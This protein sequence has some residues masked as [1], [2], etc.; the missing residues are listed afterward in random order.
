MKEMLK[1]KL[2]ENLRYRIPAILLCITLA[3]GLFVT[4]DYSISNYLRLATGNIFN[5]FDYLS[6]VGINIFFMFLFRFLTFAMILQFLF[7]KFLGGVENSSRLCCF[8]LLHTLIAMFC[9]ILIF[10][11]IFAFCGRSIEHILKRFYINNIPRYVVVDTL[12]LFGTNW[13]LY[14][15]FYSIVFAVPATAVATPLLYFSLCNDTKSKKLLFISVLFSCA[16]CYAQIGMFF[17]I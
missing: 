10:V 9:A 4:R 13:S 7:I 12:H 1:N 15:L 3:V 16:V 11:I 6:S 2:K 5:A 8:I 17:C 14:S